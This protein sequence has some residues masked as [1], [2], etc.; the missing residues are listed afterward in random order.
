MH[1][2]IVKPE[3]PRLWNLGFTRREKKFASVLNTA[4]RIEEKRR[5]AFE[6]M[7][8]KRIEAGINIV[9][10][11]KVKKKK[12]KKLNRCLH[13]LKNAWFIF[14][15]KRKVYDRSES[16]KFLF[17]ARNKSWTDKFVA[18][19]WNRK[20]KVKTFYLSSIKTVNFSFIVL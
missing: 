4:D 17:F 10:K 18:F 6:K 19:S 3:Q 15:G 8:T 14:A 9:I 13:D 16:S 11:E 12:K 7:K 2:E 1:V 5:K 20:R